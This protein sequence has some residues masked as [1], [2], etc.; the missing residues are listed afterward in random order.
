MITTAPMKMCTDL[1][2]P[3][4]YNHEPAFK[5]L[6]RFKFSNMQTYEQE[7]IIQINIW[8][9]YKKVITCLKYVQNNENPKADFQIL[10]KVFQFD[11]AFVPI[12]C[13]WVFHNVEVLLITTYTFACAFKRF[14]H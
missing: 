10:P 1:A 12:S 7:R 6:Q 3:T 9:L 5:H 8:I 2:V 4:I 14:L 13:L 11:D